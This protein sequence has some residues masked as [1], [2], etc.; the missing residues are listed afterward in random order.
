MA[1]WDVESKFR[2]SLGP[3]SH[4][5]LEAGRLPEPPHITALVSYPPPLLL[6]LPFARRQPASSAGG[7]LEVKCLAIPDH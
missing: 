2:V 6:L 1:V 3:Q 5:S 7:N 4:L